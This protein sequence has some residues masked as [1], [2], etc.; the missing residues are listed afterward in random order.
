MRRISPPVTIPATPNATLRDRRD[1]DR[2]RFGWRTIFYGFLRSRRRIRRRVCDG[3]EP[4]VDWHHPWLFF[5]GVGV[6]LLSVTDAFLTLRLLERGAIEI[7]P[8]M[9]ILI[10]HDTL[11]FVSTKLALTGVGLLLLVYTS[12]LLLFQRVRVGAFI[13]AFFCMYACLICYE[14]LGLIATVAP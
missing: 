9:R 7:N 1:I 14:Y 2:R 13:T 8:F 11:V 5:L 12:Q 10:D 4:F 3:A 6:M